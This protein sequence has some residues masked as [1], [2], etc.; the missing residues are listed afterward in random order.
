MRIT[1]TLHIE[2]VYDIATCNYIQL[3]LNYYSCRRVNISIVSSCPGFGLCQC[4]I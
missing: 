1:P 2:G 3:F 4:F